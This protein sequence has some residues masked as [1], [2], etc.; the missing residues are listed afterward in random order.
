MLTNTRTLF[1][2][3]ALLLS[4]AACAPGPEV[5]V[6]DLS[7]QRY[8]PTSLIEALTAA[9][10]RPYTVIAGLRI[11]GSPGTDRAQLLASLRQK[12][13]ALGANALIIHDESR[14]L[15]PSVAY[16]PSGGNYQAQGPQT[17]PILSAEAI[18][19]KQP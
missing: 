11:E 17:I 9:P 5:Q 10:S 19:W 8:A 3:A 2:G 12:A 6:T 15:P 18:R 4:L 7:P 1:T 14:T 16:N 13:A